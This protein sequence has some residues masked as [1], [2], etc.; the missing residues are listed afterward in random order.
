MASMKEFAFAFV[1]ETDGDVIEGTE[2]DGEATR[3]PSG[4]FEKLNLIPP[5]AG[6]E[7]LIIV[8]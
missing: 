6:I 8:P 1:E 5:F 7:Q 3:K 4:F 2:G